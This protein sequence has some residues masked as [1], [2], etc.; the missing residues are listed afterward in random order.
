M[1]MAIT[2]A[3][4][5]RPGDVIIDGY[6]E[7]VGRG[8]VKARGRL[9]TVTAVADDQHREDFV[10]IDGWYSMGRRPLPWSLRI[11]R[12]HLVHT[13]VPVDADGFIP[14]QDPAITFG[15]RG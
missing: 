2:L 13:M 3:E 4:D 15:V 8:Q 1:E 9:V 11:R 7:N 14:V 12:I 5:V 10:N 6:N